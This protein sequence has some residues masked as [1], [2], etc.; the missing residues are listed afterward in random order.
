MNSQDTTVVE[1]F[2]PKIQK[3][4][5]GTFSILHDVSPSPCIVDT[6]IF[7]FFLCFDHDFDLL[8]DHFWGRRSIL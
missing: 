7:K 6:K 1:Q 4:Q 8:W 5:E 3:K 2:E